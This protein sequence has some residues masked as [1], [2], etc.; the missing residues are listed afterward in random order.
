VPCVD[1]TWQPIKPFV[2]ERVVGTKVE[3]FDPTGGPSH[4]GCR[5]WV[6]LKSLH[7]TGMTKQGKE[8]KTGWRLHAGP[9]GKRQDLCVACMKWVDVELI[10]EGMRYTWRGTCAPCWAVQKDRYGLTD[11]H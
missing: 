2:V 4:M 1:W 8:R 5:R 10:D 7:A 9:P 3:V 6:G 11:D